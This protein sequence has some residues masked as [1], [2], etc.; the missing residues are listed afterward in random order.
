V[1]T[2]LVKEHDEAH[3]AERR[4]GGDF[5]ADGTWVPHRYLR[6]DGQPDVEY[7]PASM[8]CYVMDRSQGVAMTRKSYPF[9]G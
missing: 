9:S 2:Q 6:R 8:L 5:A 4:R 3:D 1:A 7:A